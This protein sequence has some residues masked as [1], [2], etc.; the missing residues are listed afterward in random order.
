M[1]EQRL[2]VESRQEVEVVVQGASLICQRTPPGSWVCCAEEGAP[3]CARGLTLESAVANWE[4]AQLLD[5]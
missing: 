4:R 3:S 5:D 2:E 1:E